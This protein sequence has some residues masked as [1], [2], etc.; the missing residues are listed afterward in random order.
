MA[1]E[2]KAVVCKFITDNVWNGVGL[3]SQEEIQVDWANQLGDDIVFVKFEQD[4]GLVMFLPNAPN[5]SGNSYGVV[6][7]I[8]SPEVG[9]YRYVDNNLMLSK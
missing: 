2:N 7:D 8:M 3:I 4:G 9:N 5:V 1:I 6:I